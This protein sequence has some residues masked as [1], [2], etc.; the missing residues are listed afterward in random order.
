MSLVYF[1]VAACVA[2]VILFCAAMWV[3]FGEN[4]TKGN[5]NDR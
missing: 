2:T 5:S 3:F 4:V 1:D